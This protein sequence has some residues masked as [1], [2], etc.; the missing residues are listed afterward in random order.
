M[1]ASVGAVSCVANFEDPLHYLPDRGQWIELTALDLIEQSPELRVVCDRPLEVRLRA[2]RSNGEN[3]A[4]QVLTPTFLE[5]ALR[6]EMR[7][8]LCDLR[9]ELRHVL[10]ARRIR[11]DDGRP[12]RALTV[13]RQDRAH[14][15]HH[16]PR[17]RM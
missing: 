3:L 17:R 15:V 12:P 1:S 8:V 13:E 6:F 10:A 4:G 16:R 7:P 14:L 2:P 9:P 5:A 11:E